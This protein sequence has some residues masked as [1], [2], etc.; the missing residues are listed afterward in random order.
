MATLQESL[1]ALSA[2]H[3][4]NSQATHR[5]EILKSW[6]EIAQDCTYD[7]ESNI[8]GKQTLDI[9]CGQGDMIAVFAA[10][11]K[12]QG[13]I[14][15]KVVGVDPASVDY[16]GQFRSRLTTSSQLKGIL[17]EPWTL[18]EAQA[19]LSSA[20]FGGYLS[21]KQ[22]TAPALV[23]SQPVGTYTAAYFAHSL[24]YFPS[25]ATVVQT[26]RSLLDASVQ[27]LLIA[28]WSLSISRSAA[29]PH[30]LAVLLQSMDPLP[31]GNIR[32]VLSPRG[33]ID[34]AKRAG[35]EAVGTRILTP[36][37][38][39]EDGKWEVRF[40]REVAG[41]RQIVEKIVQMDEERS[42]ESVRLETLRAHAD[43]LEASMVEVGAEGVECMNVWTAV[44]RP[45]GS[46]G[47][48]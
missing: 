18:G 7:L 45:A 6:L 31:E 4:Q 36:A 41:N 33:Y 17:G 28:E 2:S 43:S 24:Y 32:T 26:F 23:A 11:L 19:E 39:L 29:L 35:W 38:E 10:A 20:P 9:G 27:T 47:G 1:R 8:I 48:L 16:G 30:L 42:E 46:S 21:F 15:S 5:V 13:N 14:E 37:A 22:I 44:L 12:E 40:A 3:T 34:A 25:S